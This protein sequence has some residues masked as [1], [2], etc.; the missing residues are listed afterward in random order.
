MNTVGRRL[1]SIVV[2]NI[3]I[4]IV[5]STFIERCILPPMVASEGSCEEFRIRIAAR[6]YT[7]V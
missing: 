3:T 1:A 7:N 2:T 5:G 6:H 4:A